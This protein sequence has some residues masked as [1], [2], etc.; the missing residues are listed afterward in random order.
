MK[1]MNV[2]E[3]YADMNE[4][5]RA[6]CIGYSTFTKYLR[7]RSVSKS[8]LDTDFEPKIEEENFIDAPILEALEECSFSSLRQI[9]KRIL[10]PMSTVRYHF[11]NSLG[12]QIRNIR[13]VPHS[14]SLIPKQTCVVMSQYLL[15]A[16]RLAKHH[17]WKYRASHSG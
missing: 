10:I 7:E 3:I 1:D 16:L 14:L 9:A 15:Q 11:V 2:R 12:Y 8:M 6:D 5:H 17:A 13:W 4:T